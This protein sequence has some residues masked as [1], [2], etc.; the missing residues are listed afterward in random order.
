MRRTTANARQEIAKGMEKHRQAPRGQMV[1]G[2]RQPEVD[3][4]GDRC[5]NIARRGGAPAYPGSGEQTA[6]YAA[7]HAGLYARRKLVITTTAPRQRAVLRAKRR[8]R[9]GPS[10]RRY[11]LRT[12]R[13]SEID[14]G[15][16]GDVGPHDQNA[17]VDGTNG[18]QSAAAGVENSVN[19]AAGP[20]SNGAHDD[21]FGGEPEDESLRR[22]RNARAK[23]SARRC[24]FGPDRRGLLFLSWNANGI[25]ENKR[26]DMGFKRDEI[27]RF[28]SECDARGEHQRSFSP[29]I[30]ND[31]TRDAQH[32][33]RGL[34]GFVD[35]R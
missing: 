3:E 2:R 16:A 9:S 8:K 27:Q 31:L 26:G 30:R 25:C 14:D 34:P 22:R 13:L 23:V 10:T 1:K 33:E 21:G 32:D 11:K 18:G 12:G 7:P 6:G 24:A 4:Y 19:T 35:G 15:A 5:H 20:S 17:S 28:L 29:E